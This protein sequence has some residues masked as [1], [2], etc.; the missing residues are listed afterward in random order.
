M[1]DFKII[2]ETIIRI[3]IIAFGGWM[4]TILISEI[5]AETRDL[6][7]NIK[8]YKKK[9]KKQKKIN[10][11]KLNDIKLERMVLRYNDIAIKYY[12]EIMLNSCQ[13]MSIEEIEAI[14]KYIQNLTFPIEEIKKLDKDT[15]EHIL[16]ITTEFVSKHE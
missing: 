13:D 4:L 2:I 12:T 8:E 6:V 9:E 16:K 7:K 3:L 15:K 5:I 14:Y 11:D 1:I 10:K